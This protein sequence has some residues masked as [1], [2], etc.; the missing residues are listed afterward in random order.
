MIFK[1]QQL[2]T[3]FNILPLVCYK[4]GKTSFPPQHPSA[5]L[6]HR[7][8]PSGACARSHHLSHSPVP[9][10]SP[11]VP[12]RH[13]RASLAAPPPSRHR[14]LRSRASHRAPAPLPERPPPR[15]TG[16]GGLGRSGPLSPPRVPSAAGRAQRPLPGAARRLTGAAAP[17]ATRHAA[18]PPASAGR[19]DPTRTP[20]AAA[21]ATAA[22]A[23]AAPARQGPARPRPG[24]HPAPG[25]HGLRA[26]APAAGGPDARPRLYA[27]PGKG[28]Q[29]ERSP[30][31][32]PLLPGKLRLRA[33]RRESPD[34]RR[35]HAQPEAEGGR[36]AAPPLPSLRPSS[37]P[38]G[39]VVPPGPGERLRVAAAAALPLAVRAPQPGGREGSRL[40]RS[41]SPP[42]RSPK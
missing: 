21:A 38:P 33:P 22:A 14:G 12:P 5:S 13:G 16:D 7:H 29:G 28:A 18:P 9:A 6:K 20:A 26:G 32:A 1:V 2:K 17:D 19:R 42:S 36:R 24:P 37:L 3:P 11:A 31:P 41:A 27:E 4:P 40:L 30:R 34:G 10:P 25:T 8:P 39:R 15:E 35:A 23:A